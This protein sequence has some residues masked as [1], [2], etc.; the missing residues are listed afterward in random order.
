MRAFA[1]VFAAAVCAALVTAPLTATAQ[2]WAKPRLNNSP[3]HGEWVEVKSGERTVKAF[4]VYP[5]RKD[6]APVV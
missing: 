4:V 5:E 6:K 1:R 3:R 2:D